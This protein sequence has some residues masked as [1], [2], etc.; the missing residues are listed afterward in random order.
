M[1]ATAPRSVAADAATHPLDL[2]TTEEFRAVREVL[3]DAG[4]LGDTVRF[5]LRRARGAATRR[6]SSPTPTAT[7]STGASAS[8]CST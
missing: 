8:C 5:V 2:A 6:P 7:P 4:L 1:T 3:A